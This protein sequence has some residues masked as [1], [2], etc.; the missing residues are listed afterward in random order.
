MPSLSHIRHGAVALLAASAVLF[1]STVV[2]SSAG[3]EPSASEQ[4]MAAMVNDYRARNGLPALQLH[5]GMSADSRAWSQHMAGS[6]L[7][8]DPNYPASCERHFSG[9]SRCS[10]N[11]G[12]ATGGIGA[13]Q[14]AFEGSSTHRS[15]LLCACTHLGIGVVESGGRTWVTQR[16]VHQGQ[17][18]TAPQ[19][20]QAQIDGAEPFVRAVYA[21]FVS[22]DPSDAD[23]AHWKPRAVTADQRAQLVRALAYSS[24]SLGA[25]VDRYY[26]DALGRPAD[27]A[28]RQYWTD[29][30]QRG[31]PLADLAVRF[32][33]SAE[34]FEG[35]NQDLG[36]WVDGLYAAFFDRRAD[37]SGRAH[38]ARAAQT[39]GRA[40]VTR[41]L[42]DSTESVR[43]RIGA[44]YQHL[45]A[46][47]ADAGGV[48]HWTSMLRWTR[49][50]V[51]L[52]ETLAN[53][54]EY[55]ARAGDRY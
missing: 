4:Q 16:F 14:S 47:A 2:A 46:R 35:V 36:R 55:R 6:G 32:Y 8:H 12:Y 28:G 33:A 49:N 29:Q 45:L 34:H 37:D 43:L 44:A 18:A 25:I 41:A 38:W 24:E 21:D 9:Y 30:L 13:V 51:H 40:A 20:S 7:A 39:Y 48:E 54:A 26:Q 42:H 3:A 11:V 27:A 19:Y 1:G 10:E 50:D 52:A 17:T 5:T 53:S 22:R 23:L 15:N 31:V